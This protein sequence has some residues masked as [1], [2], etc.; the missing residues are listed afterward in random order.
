MFSV[1]E[2]PGIGEYLVPGSP[3]D[4]SALE[5]QAPRR[6]PVLGEHTDQVL[7]EV[8]GMGDGQIGA[9]RDRGIV[10]GPVEL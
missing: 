9:L 5:R 7:A 4:F 3:L 10:A 6:A 2:Q 8:L 1:L